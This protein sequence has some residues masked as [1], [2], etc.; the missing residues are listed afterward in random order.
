M[1]VILVPDKIWLKTS[2]GARCVNGITTPS[3]TYQLIKY[4]KI[5]YR[6]IEK[7][8]IHETRS[9]LLFRATIKTLCN[10]GMKMELYTAFFKGHRP[11]VNIVDSR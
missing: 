6:T 5:L 11:I 4:S 10:L 9:L 3:I 2:I 7:G 1:F 8:Q